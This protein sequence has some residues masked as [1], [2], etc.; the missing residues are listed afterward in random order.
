MGRPLIDITGQRFGRL[1]AIRHPFKSNKW[2]CACDCG[3]FTNVNGHQLRI[4]AIKSCGCLNS[5]MSAARKRTHGMTGTKEYSAWFRMKKRC[6]D[7]KDK[8]WEDYGG[9]GISV[10]PE[11]IESF[12]LFFQ[13][14][15]PATSRLHQLDRIDNNGNYEPGNVRWAT[16]DTQANNTRRNTFLTHNGISRTVAELSKEFNVGYH[17]LYDRVFDLGW[18]V[19]DAIEKPVGP[20]GFQIGHPSYVD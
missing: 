8:R 7:P 17:L 5:E 2:E 16:R 1:V 18:T 11:W 15:G 6:Q 3:E 19:A 4:G 13:H 20:A 9:R 10:H 12:E 14:I